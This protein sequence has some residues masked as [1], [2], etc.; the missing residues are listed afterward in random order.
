VEIYGRTRQ[1]TVDNII[2]R[3]RFACRVN[4]ATETLRFCNAYCFTQQQQLRER[5]SM[6]R[7]HLQQLSCF[8]IKLMTVTHY[9]Q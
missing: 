9:E 7:L 1:A 8:C 6:L 2:R 5:A 3:M 4:K